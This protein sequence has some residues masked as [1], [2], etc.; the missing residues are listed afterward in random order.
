MTIVVIPT[1]EY[2]YGMYMREKGVVP[3]E[4]NQYLEKE[5][6]LQNEV[7]TYCSD[8]HIDCVF[9]ADSLVQM[10]RSGVAIY[11]TSGNSHPIARGYQSIAETVYERIK[12]EPNLQ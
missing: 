11:P 8:Q 7:H 10:L 3:K 12:T 1:K 9:T 2:V 5:E 4:M 6:L